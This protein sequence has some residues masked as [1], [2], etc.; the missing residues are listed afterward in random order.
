MTPRSMPL[1]RPGLSR[2][3]PVT[4]ALLTLILVLGLVSAA[5]AVPT[6]GGVATGDP[7]GQGRSPGIGPDSITGLWA[8]DY[9]GRYFYDGSTS[10]RMIIDNRG[11]V[12]LTIKDGGDPDDPDD[13]RAGLLAV[14]G[15]DGEVDWFQPAVRTNC[16]PLATDDGLIYAF[17]NRPVPGERDRLVVLEIDADD[18]SVLRDWD[19][20]E[21]A[22]GN[23]SCR[24]W[25]NQ[26]LDDT[27]VF[28]HDIGFDDRIVAL[29]VSGP[30]IERVWETVF[31]GWEGVGGY[32]PITSPDGS[33][34]YTVHYDDFSRDTP[35]TLS[36]Y[37]ITSGQELSSVDVGAQGIFTSVV[38]VDGGPRRGGQGGQ[39]QLLHRLTLYARRR[40]V[41]TAAG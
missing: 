23:S 18:G 20:G 2:S 29:D 40:W 36:V 24:G 33:L 38:A 31:G 12:L 1:P 22:P 5:L 9:D 39:L 34:L 19:A 26:G 25:M 21:T 8:Q 7:A 37:D 6:P 35:Y 28:Q 10:Q 41:G 30:T 3:T 16:T 11:H 17:G 14:D 4:V 13:T 32:P 15:V 27:I